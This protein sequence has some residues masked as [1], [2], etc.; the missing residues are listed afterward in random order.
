M[1]NIGI[2]LKEIR[3]SK[4]LSRKDVVEKL[5]KY[6]LDISDKTIYGYEVGRTSA[7]ADMFLALC[8]IYE[9]D[10]ILETFGYNTKEKKITL[11]NKEENIIR[12]YRDLDDYGILAVDNT[13]KIE[14]NR[15]TSQLKRLEA[16][17]KGLSDYG[18]S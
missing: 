4:G 12:Q 6:G 7:N 18:K 5:K 1:N 13:L 2:K 15:K 8:E 9:I 3:Q 16:Y 17:A 11:S 14:V 10:D